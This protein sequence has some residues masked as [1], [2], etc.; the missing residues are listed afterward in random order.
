MVLLASML[1]EN[2]FFASKP[3]S[4]REKVVKAMDRYLTSG[5]YQ[6]GSSLMKA[7]YSALNGKIDDIDL[8]KFECV[9]GIA[10]LA[11]T[12]PTAFW[13]IF[14]IFSDPLVL[15]VVRE[16][17]G[18]ITESEHSTEK[19]LTKRIDLR[20]I[21]DAPIIFSVIQEAMRLRAT[22]TGPRMVMEDINIGKENYLLKKDSVVIIANKALHYDKGAWGENSGTFRS[23]RFCGKFPA[24]AFRGFG[25]GVN[26]CPG[27]AFAMVEIAALVAML[28]MRYDLVPEGGVWTEPGQNLENMSLQTA[29][30][31]KKVVVDIVPREH[32]EEA[33]WTF[34]L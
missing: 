11:N 28:A 2:R 29:P 17:V 13:T 27:R 4:G 26:L 6:K 18:L 34:A 15:N 1:P 12:V 8:A 23:D 33:S 22:G 7:R 5:A 20:K 24:N 9:N 21:K 19:G 31:K 16:Q 30:P 3:L 25:G 10:I 14:H 32:L